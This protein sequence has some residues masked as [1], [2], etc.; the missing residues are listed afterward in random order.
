MSA[1]LSAVPA[2]VARSC[3]AL[4]DEDYAAFLAHCAADFRYAIRVYSPELRKWTTWLA[5][6]RSDLEGLFAALPEHLRRRGRLLR[7]LGPTVVDD[8]GN[9]ECRAIT[10]FVVFHTGTDGRTQPWAAG[11]Y[12]DRLVADGARALLTEREVVLDTRD[13]GAGSHVP[14]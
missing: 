5:Q 11:R 2:V 7:H 9:G 13:L 8:L 14:I 12:R 1:A 10:S 4:D 3:L 6:S